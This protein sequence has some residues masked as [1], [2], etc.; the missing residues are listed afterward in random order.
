MRAALAVLPEPAKPDV[1]YRSTWL[2]VNHALNE[3]GVP[4]LGG[5]QVDR[6]IALAA[7]R[8]ALRAERDQLRSANLG[9]RDSSRENDSLTARVEQL[10]RDNALVWELLEYV[11][12]PR[13]PWG[14]LSVRARKAL[15]ARKAGG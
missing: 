1:A 10:E 8:D 13:D 9:M 12:E 14:E 15:D 7:E 3:A 11:G 4:E 6:V 2:E 5:L